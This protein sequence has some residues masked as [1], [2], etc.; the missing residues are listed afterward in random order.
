MWEVGGEKL[1]VGGGAGGLRGDFFWG[2][3]GVLGCGVLSSFGGSRE[4]FAVVMEE[5]PVF[6]LILNLK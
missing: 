1:V 6:W 5:Y 4:I 2:E 3:M